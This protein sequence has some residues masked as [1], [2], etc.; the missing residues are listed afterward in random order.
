MV[1]KQL[2]L[3]AGIITAIIVLVSILIGYKIEVD[4]YQKLYNQMLEDSIE[5]ESYMLLTRFA[6]EHPEKS[7]DSCNVLKTML[8]KQ[9]NRAN[10][11]YEEIYRIESGSIILDKERYNILRKQYF[12]ANFKLYLSHLSY[13]KQCGDEEDLELILFFYTAERE[14]PDCLVEGTVLDTLRENC[15]NVRVFAFPTDVNMD[16]LDTLNRYYNITTVP[17]IVIDNRDIIIEG[18]VDY[19]NITKYIKCG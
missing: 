19:D 11:I 2:Y 1:R 17:S 13:I 14:C 12:I 10:A 8:E 7:I 4:T 6:D 9:S 5:S 18:L 16:L 3:A 15:K